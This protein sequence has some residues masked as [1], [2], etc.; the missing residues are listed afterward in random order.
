MHPVSAAFC[1]Q[2]QAEGLLRCALDLGIGFVFCL[3]CAFF[4]VCFFT[5]NFS[6]FN[7]HLIP[8]LRLL[9]T[10]EQQNVTG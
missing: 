5:T 1:F 4:L 7:F 9:F 3:C 8:S 2:A 10:I 6:E